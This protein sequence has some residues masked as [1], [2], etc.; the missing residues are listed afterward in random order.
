[1][2]YIL[3]NIEGDFEPVETSCPK[4][5]SMQVAVAADSKGYFYIVECHKCGYKNIN[6]NINMS[7]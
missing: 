2:E 4:C 6:I 5:N 1:M 7:I 3:G